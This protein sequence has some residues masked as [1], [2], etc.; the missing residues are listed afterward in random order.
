M[1][2]QIDRRICSLPNYLCKEILRTENL[3]T[4]CFKILDFIIVHRNEYHPIITEQLSGHFEARIYH[5]EPIGVKA[6]VGLYIALPSCI[7]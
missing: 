5:V 4:D 7:M 2:H 6:T 3:I 1:F